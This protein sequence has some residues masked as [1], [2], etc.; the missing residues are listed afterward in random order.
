L[1]PF[2]W[3]HIFIPVVPQSLLSFCC[4]P[5]PFL[6]GILRVHLAE[7]KTLSDAMEEVRHLPSPSRSALMTSPLT[8]AHAHAHTTAH[9]RTRPTAR[10]RMQVVVVDVDN[11][12]VLFPEDMDDVKLVPPVLLDPLLQSLQRICREVRGVEPGSQSSFSILGSLMGKPKAKERKPLSKAL[13]KDLQNV[14]IAFMVD[15]LATYKDFM[16]K[17][18]V[19]PDVTTAAFNP[20]EN[21][22]NSNYFDSEGYAPLSHFLPISRS[23]LTNRRVRVRCVVCGV[24]G[25]CGGACACLDLLRAGRRI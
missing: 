1:Y 24:C 18:P 25:V 20:V 22:F 3:Q 23:V 7:L 16:R 10:T 15:L 14:F 2:N 13:V 11:N 12:K 17:T 6:V 9:H 5:M 4:A 21:G 8:A 19:K